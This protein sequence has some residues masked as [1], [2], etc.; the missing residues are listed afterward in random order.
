MLAASQINVIFPRIEFQRII[1]AII[2]T[3]AVFFSDGLK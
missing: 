2:P 3:G 1:A